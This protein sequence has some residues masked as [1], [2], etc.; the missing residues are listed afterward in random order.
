MYKLQFFTFT[1]AVSLGLPYLSTSFQFARL[2][3]R[4]TRP[5]FTKFSV[6]VTRVRDDVLVWWQWQYVMYFRYCGW[7]HVFTYENE[8][9]D[10]KTTRIFRPIRQ[11]AAPIRRQT[12][13]FGRVRQ[14]GGTGG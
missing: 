11:M 14:G 3:R 10:S 9:P 5:N 12:T 1:F 4:H 13:L 8:W 7:R 2:S 6:R